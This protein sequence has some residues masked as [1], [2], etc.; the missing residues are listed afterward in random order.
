[1]KINNIFVFSIFALSIFTGIKGMKEEV[2]Q[3]I[4]EDAMAKD[5]IASHQESNLQ[6]LAAG[7]EFLK[8]DGLN[9]A[10]FKLVISHVVKLATQINQQDPEGLHRLIMIHYSQLDP[11]AQRALERFTV[12]PLS[13]CEVSSVGILLTV[14]CFSG[15]SCLIQVL[16]RPEILEQIGGIPD[17]FSFAFTG[18]PI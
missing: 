15:I 6:N 4:V 18:K 16:N 17:V 8:V 10:S 11:K 5:F 14:I 2:G 12:R 3:E 13:T 7:I 9:F 1:M